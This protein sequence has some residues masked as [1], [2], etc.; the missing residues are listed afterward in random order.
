MGKSDG[1]DESRGLAG[2]P[3]KVGVAARRDAEDLTDTLVI[4]LHVG[5]KGNAADVAEVIEDIEEILFA[6]VKPRLLVR[7]RREIG[8]RVR[9]ELCELFGRD[10]KTRTLEGGAALKVD[11][12]REAMV[13]EGLADVDAVEDLHRDLRALQPVL[14]SQLGEVRLLR[15][16]GKCS[17]SWIISRAGLVEGALG[18]ACCSLGNEI[19]VDVGHEERVVARVVLARQTHGEGELLEGDVEEGPIALRGVRLA[20]DQGVARVLP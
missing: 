2:G 17:L 5:T 20:R 19:G 6:G 18:S 9:D 7:C 13:L 4:R 12:R 3:G 15:S 14:Q 8:R 16:E 11:S 10:M 1:V